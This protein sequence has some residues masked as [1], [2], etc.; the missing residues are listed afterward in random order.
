MLP[1]MVQSTRLVSSCKQSE[2]GV[3]KVGSVTGPVIQTNGRLSFE[4]DLMSE[5]LLY[6]VSQ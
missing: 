1:S 2:M 4:D 5:D 6:C 3:I